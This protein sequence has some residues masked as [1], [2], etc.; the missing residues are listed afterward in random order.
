MKRAAL[1]LVA[2][3]IAVPSAIAWVL[4]GHWCSFCGRRFDS[5]GLLT[6]HIH[7]SHLN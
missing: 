4:H 2:L 7:L 6:R 1:V 3:S 5:R